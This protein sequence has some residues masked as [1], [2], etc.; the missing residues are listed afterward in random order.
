M[1]SKWDVNSIQNHFSVDCKAI[2]QSITANS[3]E[4]LLK[5][6]HDAIACIMC[7]EPTWDTLWVGT[8][9]GHILIF[10]AVTVQLLTWFHP[11]DETRSL[12]FM[13]F[14]GPCGT[15]QGYVISTGKGLRPEGLGARDV[16]LLSAERV[17]EPPIEVTS[18]KVS[19]AKRKFSKVR[20]P[21]PPLDEPDAAE[22]DSTV[23][24]KCAMI[25]WETVSKNCFARIEA[26]SGRQRFRVDSTNK[27]TSGDQPSKTS[28]EQEP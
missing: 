21:T 23:P 22:T 26:K 12:T 28:D 3:T 13:H 8:A 11:F 9:S 10:D 20:S 5:E 16:C 14:P 18:W 27:N 25:M 19:E 17:R 4:M 24:P 1:L 2:L 7:V 6:S 15:E